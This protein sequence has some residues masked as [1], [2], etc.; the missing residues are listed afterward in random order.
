MRARRQHIGSAART[1]RK[2]AFEAIESRQPSATVLQAFGRDTL[3][4]CDRS[5][6]QPASR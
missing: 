3:Q 5:V 6:R 1:V 2:S 4:P